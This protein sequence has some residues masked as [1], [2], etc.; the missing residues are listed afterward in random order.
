[1]AADVLVF[2][3]SGCGACHDYMPKF[4]RLARPL[5]DQRRIRVQV[6]D[7][8][9][10]GPGAALAAQHKIEATPTTIV[11]RPGRKPHKRVGSLD[12]AE[13]QKLLTLAAGA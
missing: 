3:A 4:T 9:R 6:I 12:E 1:M 7:L 11:L 2:V 8:A 5:H 10:G 13:I